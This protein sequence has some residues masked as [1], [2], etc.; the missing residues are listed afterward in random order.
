MFLNLERVSQV[1][2]AEYHSKRNFVERVHA[3]EHRVLS[4]HG[5]DCVQQ[6]VT[7]GSDEHRENMEHMATEV[8]HCLHRASFGGKPLY[9]CILL[10]WH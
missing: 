1:S 8:S 7:T 3:E 9:I 2:F 10:P 5:A 6:N 4:K